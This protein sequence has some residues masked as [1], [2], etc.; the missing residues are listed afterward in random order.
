M[1]KSSGI[2][3]YDPKVDRGSFVKWWVILQCDL[4]LVRYYQHIFYKL[5]WRKLQTQ[6][7]SS[8]I[9]LVRGEEPINKDKW[10]KYNGKIIEFEYEY[11]G[12]FL[13]NGRH[14]WLKAH[15]PLFKDI[16]MS[17]GLSPEPFVPFHLSIGSRQ[18]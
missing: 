14:F 7:W 17:L 6:M 8:H 1:W 9:S 12:E 18:E 4:E 11:D 3:K 2:V 16:R 5:Y 13:N 10:K 15:S